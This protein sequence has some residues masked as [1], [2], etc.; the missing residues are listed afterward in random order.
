MGFLFALW[1]RFFGGYDSKY[2]LLEGRGIQTVICVVAVFLW[3]L[4]KGYTWWAS[5]IIGVLVYIFWCRGHFVYFKC[6]EESID[7]I[8]EQFARGRKPMFFNQV[9]WISNKL[10]FEQFSR[11][12]CFVGLFLRYFIY[13]L[14]ISIIIGHQFTLAAIMIPFIYNACYW[15]NFPCIKLAKSPTN[16]AEL[17]SGFVVGVGLY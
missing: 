3:E 6:G 2:D 7:Y 16:W 12:W 15:I 9:N 1:R 11:Q 14:P 8:Q 13:S 4:Y 17:I 5:L 10:G